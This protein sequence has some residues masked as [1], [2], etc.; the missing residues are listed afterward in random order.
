[1]S[2]HS[3]ANT[4]QVLQDVYGAELKLREERREVTHKTPR[5]PSKSRK[6]DEKDSDVFRNTELSIGRTY[7]QARDKVGGSLNRFRLMPMKKE[8][9]SSEAVVVV[10]SSR[11]SSM[12]RESQT[13]VVPPISL[14]VVGPM[15]AKKH[16]KHKKRVQTPKESEQKVLTYSERNRQILTFAESL[17]L[18]GYTHGPIMFKTGEVRRATE[19]FAE[20]AQLLGKKVA[21]SARKPSLPKVSLTDATGQERKLSFS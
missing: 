20:E 8:V 1:M 14:P 6:T 13:V 5:P 4:P 12:I 21:L 15:A 19:I 11:T 3:Y 16:K 2:R 9:V 10:K 7:E 17:R 18:T